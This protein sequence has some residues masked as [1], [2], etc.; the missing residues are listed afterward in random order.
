MQHKKSKDYAKVELG[1]AETAVADLTRG[2]IQEGCEQ[3]NWED[4]RGTGDALIALSEALAPDDYPAL[5]TAAAHFLASTA[6][7]EGESV[8]WGEEVWD[9]SI[10]IMALC[11][12]APVDRR[13]VK[14]GAMWLLG[15]YRKS[16]DNW[17][18]EPWETLWALV[19]MHDATLAVP[20]L[21]KE[22][23]PKPALRWLLGVIDAKS[24]LLVNQ[25]Y[26]AQFLIASSRWLDHPVMVD[27]DSELAARLQAARVTAAKVLHEPSRGGVA[28]WAPD[29]WAN[30]LIVWG[31]ADSGA[32]DLDQAWVDTVSA[33]FQTMMASDLPTEDRAFAVVALARMVRSVASSSALALPAG[34]LALE[35]RN[36]D[37]AFRI[38]LEHIRNTQSLKDA[39]SQ[40]VRIRPYLEGVRDFRDKPPFVTRRSVAGYY[41]VH[42]RQSTVHILCI[43][44]LTVALTLL[45]SSAAQSMD[46]RLALVLTAIPIGLGS[47]ASLAQ[48]LD[49]RPRE[50]F[51]RKRHEA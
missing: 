22:F 49:V 39:R 30:A 16:G 19:A 25:H 18:S 9:T 34:L 5:R 50:W 47:L 43:L 32:I 3:G 42:V 44:L 7:A 12:A 1:P 11:R 37:P 45:S 23:D 26:T 10:A 20:E 4:A 35:E 27:P 6:I 13:L 21:A 29:V 48:I 40:H 41:T 8:C 38:L 51:G 14:Q 46:S 17:Y 31:L 2:L 36:P 33:G 24:G 15:Q 28:L